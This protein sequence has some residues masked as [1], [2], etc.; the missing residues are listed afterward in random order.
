MEEARPL[1]W[2]GVARLGLVQASIGAVVVMATTT[3]NRVMVVELALPAVVP[4]ALVA[5]HHAVQVLRPRWGH[6]SDATG[7]RTPWILGGM[8]ALSLGGTGA[9]LGVSLIP[10]MP[11]VGLALALVHELICAA[12]DLARLVEAVAD[13]RLLQRDDVRIQRLEPGAHRCAP[14]PPTTTT[15]NTMMIRF[16]PISGLT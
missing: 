6:G 5:A 9:A 7:R 15:A 14:A 10:A 11:A 8:A 12:E 1:G 2:F 16:E 3:L 4:G 13:D